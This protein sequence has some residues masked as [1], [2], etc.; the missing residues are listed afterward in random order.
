MSM[1][2]SQVPVYRARRGPFAPK[3]L[4]VITIL[5]ANKSKYFH[6]YSHGQLHVGKVRKGL[7]FSLFLNDRSL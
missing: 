7:S 4:K 6:L 2:T 1:E 3:I 5:T